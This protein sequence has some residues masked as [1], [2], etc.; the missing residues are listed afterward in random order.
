MQAIAHQE[1][2]VRCCWARRRRDIDVKRAGAPRRISVDR[3]EGV[4][5]G[6]D[7]RPVAPRSEWCDTPV[8][9]RNHD[10]APRLTAR[11]THGTPKERRERIGIRIGRSARSEEH[12]SELQS[13]DHLVCRLLL[14]K[15]KKI[16]QLAKRYM[17]DSI[18][19]RAQHE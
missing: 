9:D 4:D 8:G 7:A 1:R 13:P 18:L 11:E 6:G 10:Y 12:T 15:K 19:P 5:L 2:R 16:L 17:H 3:V 14:E